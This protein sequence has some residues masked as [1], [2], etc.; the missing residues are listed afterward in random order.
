MT[1]FVEAPFVESKNKNYISSV[2]SSQ[3]LTK[4]HHQIEDE[5]GNR[6]LEQ[7][8]KPMRP[9]RQTQNTLPTAADYTVSSS[10][11]RVD[12]NLG[13][14]LSLNRFKKIDIIQRYFLWHNG[15]KL[16]INNRMKTKNITDEEI[17]EYPL[18]QWIKKKSQGK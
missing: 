4:P 8:N 3:Y 15:I 6:G 13:H 9:N 18:N 7:H 1:H 11:Y 10:A 16:E 2:S 14:K 12:H 5:E 17:K